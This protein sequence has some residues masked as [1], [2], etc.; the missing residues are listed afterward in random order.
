[1]EIYRWIGK[2]PNFGDDLN[3]FL[4]PAL[5]PEVVEDPSDGA[6]LVGVG[7][8]LSNTLAAD[9]LRVVVGSGTGYSAP[10]RDINSNNWAVYSVRGPHTA[11]LLGLSPDRAI[12]DPAALLPIA[13]KWNSRPSNDAIFI[14]HWTSAND[15]I[16]RLAAE[17]ANL[18]YVDPRGDA[19]A[20]ITEIAN[21][22]LVVAES[23]HGAIIADAFRVPW[24]PVI[25]THR[26]LFKWN[27]W[28][29]SL[30]FDYRPTR[31]GL[32]A[33]LQQLVAPDAPLPERL[34]TP[35][36]STKVKGSNVSIKAR[37]L[38][39]AFNAIPRSILQSVIKRDLEAA[40]K[41]QPQLSNDS[42]LHSRQVMLNERIEQLR[43]D[44]A[45]GRIAARL[46][47]R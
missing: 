33:R 39:A 35:L 36:S 21:A 43:N 2:D 30:S 38:K 42:V 24:V 32:W 5:M 27:D 15:K 16:W 41:S 45:V 23:M 18:R 29:A 25:G 28:T 3:L 37:T 17:A 20:V 31:V 44:Y 7:T 46:S 10:P 8:V 14:P 1:M 47:V 19:K 26:S 40:S 4:W 22:R 34:P 13:L 12:I 9:K 6:L 11:H